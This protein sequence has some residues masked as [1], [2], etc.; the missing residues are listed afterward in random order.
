MNVSNDAPAVNA[1]DYFTK[2]LPIDLANM[3]QLRDEL[4]KRQGAINA[5]ESALSTKAQADS[6][7]ETTK[8]SCDRL[9]AEAKDNAEKAKAKKKDCDER[10]KVISAREKVN[11][12]NEENTMKRLNA[13]E[14]AL[15]EDR[16]EL[17][18]KASALAVAALN[19]KAAEDTH[20]AKVKAFQDKVLAL[21]A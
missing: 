13:R 4:E 11:A 16:K 12:L 19:L 7:Y 10:E 8:E 21:T 3:V 17:N 14:Q 6:Y 18:D 15:V 1:I 20:A 5:V 2:Q 9:A